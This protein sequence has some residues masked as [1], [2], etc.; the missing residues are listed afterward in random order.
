M[1]SAQKGAPAA[2]PLPNVLLIMT[3]QQRFDSLEAYGFTAG[4]TP[5]LDALARDGAVF[6]RCYA[7]NPICS[8]SRASMLTGHHLPEHGVYRLYD[9]LPDDEVLIPERLRGL[10]YQTALV[11]KLHVSSMHAEAEARHP[12]D[13][14]DVYEWCNEG[15]VRMDSPFHAYA[16]WLDEVDPAFKVRLERE[17][18]AVLHHPAHLHFSHWAA[19]RTIDFLRSRDP[20]R[21]FFCLMSLFDP[22]NPYRDYPTHA[23]DGV[24]TAGIPA[25]V[26]DDLAARP[27]SLRREQEDGYFGDA[28]SLTAAEI[29][30]MRRDYH[31]NVAFADE[32]IGRVLAALDA[33][34]LRDRTLV[35]FAS[36]HG[37]MIGDHGLLVKGAFFFDPCVRVP[38]L[39]RWPGVIEPG[40][41]VP[42]LAQLHDLA[43][44]I[45]LAAGAEPGDVDRWMPDARDLLPAA[46]DGVI[47]REAAV[48][49]Y[50]DSGISSCGAWDPP[51]HGTMWREG[52]HKL[53]VYHL[54]DGTVEGELYDLMADPDE[55]SDLWDAPERAALKARLL[56]RLLD[57]M[58]RVELAHGSRG[59]ERRPAPRHTLDNAFEGPAQ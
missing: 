14:F 30:T 17:G 16:R 53:N 55:L 56:S 34:G 44:T 2:A 5:H 57:W 7:T 38:L 41:R 51:L 49:A 40:T 35:V 59:G 11:G 21:P 54:P 32:E 50:R 13:G 39:M 8:P 43:A 15:C 20:D 33:L 27:T 22:H 46:T 45:M 26:V 9:V 1:T 31:A 58:F 10:G 47:V 25:P 48:S 36:D 42:G 24:D 3:D 18:R 52:D 28:R 6:E 12:H 4:H 23:A 37:D 29:A 19:E